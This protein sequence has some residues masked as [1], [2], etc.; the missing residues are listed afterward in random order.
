MFGGL[1][2]EQHSPGRTMNLQSH[3]GLRVKSARRRAGLTQERLAEAVSKAVETVSNIERGHSLTG[4][5]TLEQL[6]KVLNVSPGY[7]FEGYRPE[8][9]LSRRRAGL[10]QAAI[11]AAQRLSDDQLTVAVRL[12]R[13]LE[14]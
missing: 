2:P 3:I 7:F 1:T 6:S 9:R 8:R 10:E 13:A 11:D 12:L 14:G 5:E 4:L